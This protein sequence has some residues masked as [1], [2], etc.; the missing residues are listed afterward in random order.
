MLR[1]YVVVPGT[2]SLCSETT[3]PPHKD[4]WWEPG[5]PL[6][7]YLAAFGLLQAAEPFE[8]SGD[9]DGHWG[10]LPWNWFGSNEHRD[11]RSAGSALR[12]YLAPID[13]QHR[14]VVAH[15]HGLQVALYAT[16]GYGWRQPVKI[17]RLISVGSPVRKDM[18]D[19][20]Q[21]ARPN[22]GQWIHIYD[23]TG[24]DETQLAGEFGDGRIGPVRINPFADSS[25]GIPGVGHSE[26]LRMPQQFRHW[27]EQGLIDF[28]RH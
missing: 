12:Y 27:R 4:H 19:I 28:L 1:K 9:L 18:E 16:A 2:G 5:S 7:K 15:S 13:Y 26:I 3:P 20:T 24:K 22:I 17:R 11:W 8:W 10:W 14:N 23:P 21:K 25:I 6:V